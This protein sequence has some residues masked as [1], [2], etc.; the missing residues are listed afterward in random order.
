MPKINTI[1]NEPTNN[2]EESLA[3]NFVF[4]FFALSVVF[5][6]ILIANELLK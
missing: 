2:S 4:V 6:G 3:L 1:D 5:A